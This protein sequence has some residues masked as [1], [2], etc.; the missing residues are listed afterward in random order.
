MLQ[1]ARQLK[2]A[3]I[4]MLAGLLL[5]ASLLFPYW[6]VDLETGLYPKG[7]KLQIRPYRL[8]GDVAEIDE[9]NHYI[10]MR[11]LETAG[12]LE[13]KI[14]IPSIVLAALCLF[15]SPTVPRKWMIW[16]ALPGLVFPIMFIGELYWW[17]RSS[18]L[19][20]DPKAP[21]NHSIKPF[22]PPIYGQ[23]K[24]AQFKATATFSVGF[25]LSLFSALLARIA[26][27]IRSPHWLRKGLITDASILLLISLLFSYWRV[28]FESGKYPKG[29][30]LQVRP[31]RLEGSIM[32]ID[33]LNSDIGMREL[34][35]AAKFERKVAVPTII[36]ASMCLL[37]SAFTPGQPR[38]R[39]WLA[40]PSLL[41]PLIFVGQLFWWL[42]DSGL[43]LAPSAY[44]AIT[45]FVPPLIGEKT[46]GSVTTVAR[47]QTGFYFAILVS[48]VTVVALWPNDRN[49][50]NQDT[51]T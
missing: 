40:L 45:T 5:L 18:G 50:K 37:A 4:L 43:N 7:L 46:I 51:Y 28:D 6:R 49:F 13:Q 27:Y 19:N 47:F 15:I 2:L 35:T 26:V 17:L 33:K 42:R 14:A 24:I 8:E 44:R 38:I 1:K 29:L 48:L 20:L 12:Q 10:G 21:L 23:G 3:L 25:Y 22:I 9:L 11:K 30:I 41:F 39:F 16:F 32:E 31:H 34:E 36:L